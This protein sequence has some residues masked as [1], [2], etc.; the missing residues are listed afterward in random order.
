MRSLL[1]FIFLI[2]TTCCYG[3]HLKGKV[4]DKDTKLPVNGAIVTLGSKQAFTNSFGEFNIATS[5]NDSLKIACFGYKTYKTLVRNVM[6]AV[7]VELE[8]AKIVLKEVIIHSNREREFKKDS[9]E[10]RSFYAKQFNYKG[11]TV[12]DAFVGK[13]LKNPGELITI[14]VLGL[15]RALTKKSTREYK[16]NKLL[17]RDEQADFVNQKLNHGL[18]AK[19][20]GLKGDTLSA[21]M[22]SY[23]PHYKLAHKVTDYEM[24]LYIK[25]CYK[26]FLKEGLKGEELFNS[27]K[28]DTAVFRL[29]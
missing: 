8:P 5:G 22:V 9:A 2:A 15:A 14:D 3:Q 28:K 19:V 29:N 17:L 27:G 21:F 20:T 11:P 1:L 6:A 12:M 23:R 10:N 18:V 4:V 13:P 24:E 16:F 7:H 25:D 26:K